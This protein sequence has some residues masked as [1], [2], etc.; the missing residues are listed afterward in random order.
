M[1]FTAIS[2]LILFWV[3]WIS[4]FNFYQNEGQFHI[5]EE[6]VG[7]FLLKGGYRAYWIRYSEGTQYLPNNKKK[8]L[9]CFPHFEHCDIRGIE[10]Q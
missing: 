5:S 4:L 7:F 9:W 2:L 10:K 1:K 6:R 8:I 3:L